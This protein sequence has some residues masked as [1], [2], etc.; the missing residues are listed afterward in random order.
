MPAFNSIFFLLEMGEAVET[1]VEKDDTS[2][3]EN[4]V[5][6]IF[7]KK[8]KLLIPLNFEDVD[9]L[10]AELEKIRDE[11]NKDGAKKQKDLNE[12]YQDKLGKKTDVEKMD[13]GSGT[14]P[15]LLK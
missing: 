11:D 10:K 6:E 9:S 7:K 2:A 3:I 14:S 4:A 1:F 15:R 12:K 13:S 5:N 8:S